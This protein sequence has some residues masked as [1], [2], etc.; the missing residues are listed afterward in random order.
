MKNLEQANAKP[1]K[2][3]STKKSKIKEAQ[4]L[5]FQKNYLRVS[6]LDQ[7]ESLTIE[8]V[9]AMK[10]S[11]TNF[12]AKI[13]VNRHQNLIFQNNEESLNLSMTTEKK[14]KVIKDLK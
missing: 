2:A 1:I 10:P 12:N 3:T 14:D 4:L 7:S 5:D 11:I 13:P 8:K 9:L 6:D